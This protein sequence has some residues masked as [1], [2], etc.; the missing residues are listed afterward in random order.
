MGLAEVLADS[1][2]KATSNEIERLVAKCPAVSI[3]EGTDIHTKE[4]APGLVS[5]VNKKP[6]QL[7]FCTFIKKLYFLF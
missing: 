7:K 6:D 1:R 4:T 2:A 3:V 5:M